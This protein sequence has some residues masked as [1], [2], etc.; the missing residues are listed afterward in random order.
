MDQQKDEKNRRETRQEDG[1][2][3]AKNK[4]SISMSSWWAKDDTRDRKEGRDE[5]LRNDNNHNHNNMI[6]INIVIVW[7]GDPGRFSLVWL[8]CGRR[9]E[10]GRCLGSL[11]NGVRDLW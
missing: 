1:R 3:R 11:R 2:D 9:T 5:G 10:V 6:I 7:V 4:T 8:W